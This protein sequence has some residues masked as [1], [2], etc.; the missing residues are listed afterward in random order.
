MGQETKARNEAQKTALNYGFAD[1]ETTTDPD[2]CRVWA[3]GL[4]DVDKDV[5]PEQCLLGNAIEGF[6]S[7]LA[8]GVYDKV[9]FHNLA[10]DG[11]FVLSF[12][13][14]R[15]FKVVDNNP[16][17]GEIS[18][19]ISNMGKYYSI[20]IRFRTGVKVTLLDSLKKLPFS[21]SGIAKAY[22][23]TEQKLHIDYDEYRAPGHELIEDERKYL[24]NDLLIGA[25]A[26]ALMLEE[27]M[28]ALTIGSDSLNTYKA[29]M[30]AFVRRFP[31]LPV[32]YDDDF[33]LAYRGG[34]TYLNPKYARQ[35]VGPG[36]V[37]DVNSLYPWVMRTQ[38]LPCG[39]PRWFNGFPWED[40]A[41][42]IS[43]TFTA[44][45]K[46]THFPI[47][48]VKGNPMFVPTQYLDRIED[49]IT[50]SVTSIDLAMWQEHY[51]MDILSYNGGYYFETETGF[52][53]EYIDHFMDIKANSRGGKRTL[54]KLHL[55]SLYG[56]FAS[57]PRVTG[58]YPV[59]EDGVIRLVEG[60]EQVKKPIY[61]PLSV[62]VTA[63]ARKKTIEAAQANYENFIYADTDSIH[64]I[65]DVP[66]GSMEIHSTKLGAWK[67][68]YNFDYA[69]F[70]R[71]KAYTERKIDLEKR[72]VLGY[73]THIAGLP[74]E[75]ADEVRLG[76]YWAGHELTGK[77]RAKR[78]RGGT[79][80]VDTPYRIDV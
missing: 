57:R 4:C 43:I 75:I 3:W 53:D 9:Y 42:I 36:T 77:L 49:P 61:T 64:V 60:E 73:E 47:I 19:L 51:D 32:E 37:Y 54:A 55:N 28:T 16:Q 44:E 56:K 6:L 40:K 8:K 1:F 7:E 20:E 76:D 45:L 24:I 59:L 14:Q 22:N 18:T 71:A 62:F 46:K 50:L 26:I 15:G 23:L 30:P 34:W 74:R 67:K 78:V 72:E 38:P 58:K 29:M 2:D 11:D 35:I 25:K 68:E 52:F 27:G 66:E 5:M 17:K 70:W 69:T 13:M 33:R 21:I 63:Y 10:F 79:V 12:L 48:Q 65:G 80:L 31:E 41:F 39:N